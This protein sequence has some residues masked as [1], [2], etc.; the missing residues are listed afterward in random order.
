MQPTMTATINQA[1]QGL[2]SKIKNIAIDFM[3]N[4]Y[5]N[6]TLRLCCPNPYEAKQLNHYDQKYVHNFLFCHV[7]ENR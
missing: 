3:I 2:S 4:D 1:V 6:F 5:P 7:F